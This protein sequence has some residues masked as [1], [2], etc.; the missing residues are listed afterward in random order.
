MRCFLLTDSAFQTSVK[1]VF[2]A[3]DVRAGATSQAAA[4]AEEGVT[5]APMTRAY[6]R[7]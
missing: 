1:G 3:G 7:G 2:A 4:A 5:A 6:L